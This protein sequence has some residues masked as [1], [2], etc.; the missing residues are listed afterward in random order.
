[1]SVTVQSER[2]REVTV[3]AKTELTAAEKSGL[4][5][6]FL[7]GIKEVGM[8]ATITA[9]SLI[10]VLRAGLGASHAFAAE[11]MEGRT[12]RSLIA[13]DVLSA[14]VYGRCVH[15]ASVNNALDRA[16]RHTRDAYVRR[17]RDEIVL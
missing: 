14:D 17:I 6:M 12:E 2:Q 5:E 13:R 9:E 8:P 7:R 3:E 11:M 1:M 10:P 4:M 16:E 15:A